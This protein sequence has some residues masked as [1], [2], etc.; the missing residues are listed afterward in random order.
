LFPFPS[1]RTHPSCFFFISYTAEGSFSFFLSPPPIQVDDNGPLP[2]L[3][4]SLGLKMLSFGDLSLFPFLAFGDIDSMN[5]LFFVP[6]FPLKRLSSFSLFPFASTPVS[7]VSFFFCSGMVFP[8]PLPS[9]SPIVVEGRPPVSFFSS[10]KV[11]GKTFFP[12]L[13]F[14][15]LGMGSMVPVPCFFFFFPFSRRREG[16]EIFS[17]PSFHF[18]LILKIPSLIKNT[19][20]FSFLSF[21]PPPFLPGRKNVAPPAFFSTGVVLDFFLFFFFPPSSLKDKRLFSS[22][23]SPP[24][25]IC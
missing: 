15:F 8:S 7:S 23:P 14:L 19:K 5:P 9:F 22:S 16:C 10:V 17:S 12:F 4:F 21:P 3:S 11:A 18:L 1:D 25:S 24:N 2:P 13:S 20:P 6:F